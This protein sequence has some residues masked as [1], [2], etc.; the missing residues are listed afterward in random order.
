MN[1]NE[2][3]RSLEWQQLNGKARPGLPKK[4]T[5]KKVLILRL[6]L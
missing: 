4:L 2:T 6:R 5:L 3:I 1:K